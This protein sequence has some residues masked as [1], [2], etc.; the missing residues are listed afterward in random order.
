MSTYMDIKG[1]SESSFNLGLASN[2]VKLKN[3]SGVLDIRNKADSA[4]L[5]V[6]ALGFLSTSDQLTLNEDATLSG[7]SWK[8]NFAR[9][10]SGMTANITYTFPASVTNGYFL[11]TDGSG[12]LSWAAVSSPSVSEKVTCDSTSFAFGD[13]GADLTMFNLPANAVVHDVQV[14]V[15][16]AFDVGTIEIG[17]TGTTDKYMTDTQNDLLEATRYESS[18]NNIPVGS[19]EAIKGTFSG[20]PTVGAGRVL[21]F[22]SIPA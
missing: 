11:T 5:N 13:F 15:D 19:V 8:M 2:A 16:T 10:T 3:N 20:S 22:Y 18:P 12:N 4:Y 14:I 9:P 7:A 1:T 21:V 17:I 6:K